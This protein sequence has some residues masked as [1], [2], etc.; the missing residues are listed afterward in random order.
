[1]ISEVSIT[2]KR[3]SFNSL[4]RCI[5]DVI[6][7][8]QVSQQVPNLR[9]TWSNIGVLL[10]AQMHNSLKL[11]I[12]DSLAHI[13]KNC[14][15]VNRSFRFFW[16]INT[17]ATN[18]E[19]RLKYFFFSKILL[20]NCSKRTTPSFILGFKTLVSRSNQKGCCFP[21]D[22]TSQTILKRLEAMQISL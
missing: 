11:R 10:R 5:P 18:I 14:Y 12:K 16:I 13:N 9:S 3:H 8:Q 19:V 4:H 17:K 1:M 15:H 20:F 6:L 7:V 21:H 2:C 22:L